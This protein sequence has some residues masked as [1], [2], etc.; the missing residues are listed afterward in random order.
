MSSIKVNGEET[1]G[2]SFAADDRPAPHDPYGI[3]KHEA[4][5]ALGRIGAETGLEVAIVRSPL[6]YGPGV[7]GNFIRLLKLVARGLPLPF[8][9][10]SNRR[11]MIYNRNLADAL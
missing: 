8:G 11:S 7:G 3:S 5:Q 2:R 6:V 4:E 9:A 1:T 10:V